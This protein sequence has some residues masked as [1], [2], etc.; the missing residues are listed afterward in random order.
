MRSIALALT[1]VSTIAVGGCGFGSVDIDAFTNAPGTEQV[2]ADLTAAVPEVLDDAVRRDVTP[3]PEQSAA[4]GDPPIILRCG[5][6]QPSREPGVALLVVNG[7]SW[8]PEAGEGGT[9]F[10]LLERAAVVEVAVPDDY[11]PEATILVELSPAV[12]EAIPT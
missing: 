8:Y 12:S 11:A 9:F 2:C 1:L 6:P 5:L 10:T 4:W 7:L 3:A